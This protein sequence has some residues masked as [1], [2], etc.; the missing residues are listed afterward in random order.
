MRG[1]LRNNAVGLVALFVALG[2]TSYAAIKLPRN[3]VKASQI[4]TGAVGSDE[5]KDGTLRSRDF[6]RGQLPAGAQGPRGETGA[7]GPQ[8]P[9]GRDGAQ[10]PPGVA[11][12]APGW[13]SVA[14]ASNELDYCRDSAKIP[15]AFCGDPSNQ[16]RWSNRAEFAPVAF[17]KDASDTVFLKGMA[18][19]E[20]NGTTRI[21]ILPPEYRPA[22][23]R[24]FP[25]VLVGGTI[26]TVGIF[27]SGEVRLPGGFNANNLAGTSFDGI[28]FRTTD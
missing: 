20:G 4:A 26:T 8:G 16:N 1:F 18:K 2:G 13:T 17:Y 22:N 15:G 6:S 3:S 7:A 24:Y 25:A 27:P 14:P 10:G 28:L 19:N 9:A 12:S 23:V 5:V 21:F 11:P